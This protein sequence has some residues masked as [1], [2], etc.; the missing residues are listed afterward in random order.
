MGLESSG[1]IAVLTV[2]FV[3][4]LGWR[5]PG[6]EVCLHYAVLF[7]I[8][9]ARIIE[10]NVCLSVLTVRHEYTTRKQL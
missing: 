2:A 3:A 10:L 4:G 9:A 8:L 1:A 5:K 6:N 7:C